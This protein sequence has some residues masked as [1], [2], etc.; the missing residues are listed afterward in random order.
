MTNLEP[1]TEIALNNILFA[2]DFSPAS[3]AAFT[4]AVAIADRYHSKLNVAHVI[5]IEAFDLKAADSA[6]TMLKQAHQQARAKMDQLLGPRLQH[7]DRYQPVIAEGMVAEVLVE[8]IRRDHIDL[9]VLG[10]RGRQTFKKLL[11]GSTAEEIF[12]VA[13]CPVLTVGPKT[14]SVPA[15]TGLR[16]ILY[17]LEF[18]PDSSKAAGYA[19]ALAERYAANLTLMNVRQDMPSSA[20]KSEQFTKP[21]E[22]WIEDHIAQGSNLRNRIR[23]ERGFGSATKAILD[24]ATKESVDTI[25]MSVTR[26]DPVMAAHLPKPDTAHEVVSGAPCPVLTIR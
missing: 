24:F 4:Y 6:A 10:T 22:S 16:H 5:S 13:S 7:G 21:V 14:S 20:S 25:V 19:V 1:R 17:P 23:F 12:R 11:L 15:K 18:A 26:L 9:A 3:E 8:M 2:T